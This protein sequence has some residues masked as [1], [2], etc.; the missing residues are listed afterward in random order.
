M[1]NLIKRIFSQHLELGNQEDF[2]SELTKERDERDTL[3][4]RIRALEY[5][6]DVQ[7]RGRF[8]KEERKH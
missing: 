3:A 6:V 4:A 2:D 5:M 1:I 7:T 8:V